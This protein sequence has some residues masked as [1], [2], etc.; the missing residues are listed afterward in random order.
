MSTPLANGGRTIV[1]DQT[2]GTRIIQ[3]FAKCCRI[4]G[5]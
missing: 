4:P 1:E 3:A 2:G 5:R